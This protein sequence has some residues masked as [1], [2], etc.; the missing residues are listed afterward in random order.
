MGGASGHQRNQSNNNLSPPSTFVPGHKNRSSSLG[1][2][3]YPY[4]HC[5]ISCLKATPTMK[6]QEVPFRPY[7]P[8]SSLP[9]LISEGRLVTGIL[10]V[11]KKNRS[12]AYVSTDGLLDADIFICGSKDRNRA[13][14][15]DMVA[16]SSSWSMRSGN[17]RR[18]RRKRRGEK[19]I[20][21]P[22]PRYVSAQ[23]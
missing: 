21:L 6:W 5:P 3:T 4:H 9:E 11:N 18:K 17:R 22:N 15:G 7:L 1:A 23:R 14:E 20:S 19:I 2:V 16:L 8:Q 13:L 12:D 10:R